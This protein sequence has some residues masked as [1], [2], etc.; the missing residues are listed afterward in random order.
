[1]WKA[2]DME[3]SMSILKA[4][5]LTTA[6]PIRHSTDPIQ[7]A[8]E[9]VLASLAEQKAMAEAKLAGQLYAPTHVV[10]RKNEQG[11]RTAMQV[12]K[13]I[14]PGFFTDAGG[15]IFFSLKYASKAIAFDGK[16]ANAIAVGNDLAALPAIID[17]LADAVRA[18]ELDTQLA[19]A[20]AERGRIL[21]KAS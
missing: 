21:R 16:G 7:R 8:R 3:N 4:L 18:G 12:P 20:A 13:R 1:M 6:Q 2:I 10:W 11:V 14:R 5:N 15:Q 19:K 17:T 9:K